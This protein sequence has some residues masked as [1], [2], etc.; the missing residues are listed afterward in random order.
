LKGRTRL[1]SLEKIVASDEGCGGEIFEFHDVLSNDEEDPA[2]KAARKM[3]GDAFMAGLSDRDLALI[4]CIVEGNPLA[5]LA[6]R[7]HL[8][9]STLMCIR[10]SAWPKRSWNSWDPRF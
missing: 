1:T 3:D 7:R 6:H 9:S 8:N 2:T 5:S 10:K 4:E